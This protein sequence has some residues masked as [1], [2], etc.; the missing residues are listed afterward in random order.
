MKVMGDQR[1]QKGMETRLDSHNLQTMGRP[2]GDAI[3]GSG[4]GSLDVSKTQRGQFVFLRQ[5]RPSWKSVWS[6]R[7]GFWEEVGEGR[8]GEGGGQ[9]GQS[10]GQGINKLECRWARNAQCN[11][12]CQI[13]KTVIGKSK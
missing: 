9:K 11:F 12:N 2:L 3:R 7:R 8:K 10:P 1:E 6:R 4:E 13:S 5:G